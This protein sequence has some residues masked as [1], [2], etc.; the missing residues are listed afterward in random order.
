[1]IKE[2]K[3]EFEIFYLYD[4]TTGGEADTV[5]KDFRMIIC[6]CKKFGLNVNTSKCE[7]FFCSE[8]ET[9]IFTQFDHVCPGI[10]V[11]EKLTLLGSP[12]SENAIEMVWTKKLEELKFLFQRL[13]TLDS[14]HIGIFILK[15][16]FA[17]PKLT[18]ILRT[19][20]L[21]NHPDLIENMDSCIKSILETLT[22]CLLDTQQRILSSLPIRCGGLGIR[23]VKEVF[24]PAFLSSI[25]CS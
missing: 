22:N 16:C 2:L 18:Y 12:I 1:M 24:L 8:T 17:L 19:A 23:S 20:P 4:G 9:N 21:W 14:Y 5:L 25:N 6:E 10:E 13:T 7:L 3:S 11:V 15:N